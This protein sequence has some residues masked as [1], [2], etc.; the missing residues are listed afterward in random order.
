MDIDQDSKLFLDGGRI[1]WPAK[2][3]LLGQF[4]SLTGQNIGEKNLTYPCVIFHFVNLIVILQR[5]KNE[6]ARATG[7]HD[8]RVKCLAGQVA[9]LA[10]HCS[11]TGRYFETSFTEL[12]TVKRLKSWHFV[13]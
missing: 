7:L 3:L 1:P 11:L 10:G 2:E 5:D 4:S 6:S 13:H 12:A 9:I 8:W